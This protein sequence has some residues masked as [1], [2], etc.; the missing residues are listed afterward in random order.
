MQKRIYLIRTD[1][2]WLMLNFQNDATAFKDFITR[3]QDRVYNLVLNRVQHREDAEE[4]TQD[5]FVA[6]FHKP[7]AFRGESS[8]STWLYR[9]AINKSIDHLRKQ[10]SRGARFF[11]VV[12][13][14]EDPPDF[15][16]PG[17]VS[18]NKEK[19]A[20]LFRAMKQ[21]PEKQHTAWILSEMENLS[22]KEISE[23]MNVSVSSVESLLFRARRNLK[24]ILSAIYAEINKKS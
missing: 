23:V 17:V 7:Q 19:T 1:Q 18:E 12:K 21:L 16:H 6:V 24:K 13:K 2:D 4:I 20:I 8:V 15:D 14:T 10:K 9:I 22:Y 11:S 5:V 3:Y